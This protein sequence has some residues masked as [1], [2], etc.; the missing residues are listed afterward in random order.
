MGDQSSLTMCRLDLNFKISGKILGS[1][2]DQSSLT[3]CSL[4]VSFKISGKILGSERGGSII[5]DHVQSKC[6]L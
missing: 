3:M 1:E 5:F 2:G 6:K 4:N